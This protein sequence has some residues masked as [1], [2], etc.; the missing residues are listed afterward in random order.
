VGCRPATRRKKQA[1]R[2]SLAASPYEDTIA[3]N[4]VFTRFKT[5][6][7]FDGRLEKRYDIQRQLFLAGLGGYLGFQLWPSNRC[8]NFA[9][10]AVR[11]WRLLGPLMAA[12]RWTGDVFSVPHRSFTEHQRAW[13]LQLVQPLDGGI[14]DKIDARRT[15]VAGVELLFNTRRPEGWPA[16]SAG[17]TSSSGSPDVR[18]LNVILQAPG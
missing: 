5:G 11:R 13:L 6:T 10:A 17:H 14:F 15:P 8:Q 3:S 18:G 1:K 7:K 4:F 2:L 9:R 12:T 16:I